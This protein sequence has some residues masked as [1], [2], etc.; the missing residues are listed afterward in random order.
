M[1]CRLQ[2]FPVQRCEVR[3][4][5]F[6]AGTATRVAQGFQLALCPNLKPIIPLIQLIAENPVFPALDSV[7]SVPVYSLVIPILWR[8]GGRVFQAQELEVSRWVQFALPSHLWLLPVTVCCQHWSSRRCPKAQ[9]KPHTTM[10][11]LRWECVV[12][13]NPIAIYLSWVKWNYSPRLTL[14][15][16][17]TSQKSPC[18]R[19]PPSMQAKLQRETGSV[20]RGPLGTGALVYGPFVFDIL[21]WG[22]LLR[23]IKELHS[24]GRL[25]KNVL[26]SSYRWKLVPAPEPYR[27]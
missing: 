23:F 9:K 7:S 21:S 4:N 13:G 16:T 27:I 25:Y 1:I 22:I 5:G 24:K 12:F 18:M 10:L 19:K 11:W 2:L 26:M 3:T 20:E 15:G 17:M 14:L 8:W 6:E